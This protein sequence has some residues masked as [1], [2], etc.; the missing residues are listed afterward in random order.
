[1]P[2][3]AL[4]AQKMNVAGTVISSHAEGV[5]VVELEPVPRGA[6]STLLVH[7]AT[8]FAVALAHRTPDSGG[9]VA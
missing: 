3:A 7:V 9:D 4:T 1:M 5:S 8:A 6:A 2:R